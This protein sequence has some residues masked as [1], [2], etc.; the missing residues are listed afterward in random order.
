MVAE[1]G[2]VGELTPARLALVRHLP[3]VSEDMSIVRGQLGISQSTRHT[4]KWL[5]GVDM[6]P[7]VVG[8]CLILLEGQVT[9]LA[10][11]GPLAG[12]YPPVRLQEVRL[13]ET[14]PTKLTL[15]RRLH[16]VVHL[17]DLEVR[18]GEVALVAGVTPERPLPRVL[19]LMLL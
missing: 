19:H 17:V 1:A 16:R 10:F 14:L 18:L 8:Q 11:E 6:Q 7:L 3:L 9:E 4:R 5:V 13:V 12:V 2:V 15:E